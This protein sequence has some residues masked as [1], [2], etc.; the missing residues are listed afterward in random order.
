M[1]EIQTFENYEDVEIREL[2]EEEIELI[3]GGLSA[4]KMTA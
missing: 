3:G 2:S 1:K 4:S